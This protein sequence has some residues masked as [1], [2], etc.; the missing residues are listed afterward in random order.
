ML[1]PYL[2]ICQFHSFEE[3]VL[4]F[5]YDKCSDTVVNMADVV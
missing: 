1:T 4:D 3:Y 5:S 2:I